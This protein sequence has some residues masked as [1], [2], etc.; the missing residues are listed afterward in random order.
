M[1]SPRASSSV[2]ARAAG[3][4]GPASRRRMNSPPSPMAAEDK[5]SGP[6]LARPRDILDPPGAGRRPA[7]DPIE[8]PPAKP[9]MPIRLLR[10]LLLA[11]ALLGSAVSPLG[12]TATSPYGVNA[13]AP[14]GQDLARLFDQLQAVGLGWVRIDFEWT[15]IEPQQDVFRWQTY[16]AIVAAAELR[17]LEV[18]GILAYTPAWATDGEPRAGV[19][20]QVADWEDLCFRAA[21]RYRGRVRAWEIWNEPNLDRFFAGSRTQYIE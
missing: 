2:A 14:Q 3:A 12:A 19:P 10:P 4:A 16:D 15:A 18:L 1:I 6:D 11:V 7:V 5:A 17:G 21:A 13:H 9:P 20:R 8:A